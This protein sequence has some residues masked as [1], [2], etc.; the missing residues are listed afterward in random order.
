MS[1]QVLT[2]R[3][4]ITVLSAFTLALLLVLVP[5]SAGASGQ[6]WST[7]SSP[8]TGTSSNVLD[9]VSCVSASDCTAVG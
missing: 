9:S 7:V 2:R 6:S 1:N 3:R 4:L 5:V 8:N